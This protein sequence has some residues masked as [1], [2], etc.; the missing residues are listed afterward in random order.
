MTLLFWMGAL[1]LTWIAG[2]VRLS[3]GSLAVFVPSVAL[4][5][6][7]LCAR[8]SRPGRYRV[9]ALLCGFC[10]GLPLEGRF[11]VP[12]IVLLLLGALASGTR[13]LLSAEGP[14]GMFLLGVAYA[15]LQGLL[16]L[17]FPGAGSVIKL[18]GG[19]LIGAVGRL[20][21]SGVFFSGGDTFVLRWRRVRHALERP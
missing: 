5:A 14:A 9:T 17:L 10:A 12:A 15:F 7:L 4:C 3:A 20:V 21:L 1:M 16:L 2:L 8:R 13:R 11:L 18:S 6:V 19:E